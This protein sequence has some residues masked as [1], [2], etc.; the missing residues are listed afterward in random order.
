MEI[1]LVR[2]R[3]DMNAFVQA[4][5]VAQGSN[6]NWA[7]PLNIEVHRFF[8]RRRSPFAKENAIACFVAVRDGKPAGRIAAIVNG[9]RLAHHKDGTGHFDFIEA[10]DDRK[11]FARLTDEARGILKE[12]GLTRMRG[13]NSASI[14]HGGGLPIEGLDQPHMMERQESGTNGNH[15]P[16]AG[17]GRNRPPERYQVR[18]DALGPRD[19]FSRHPRH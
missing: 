18:R 4:S 11:V 5:F 9:A 3:R 17:I 16:D 15:A 13:A 8:D 2:P 10:I 14:N 1:R 12:C 6:A 19:E 7:P